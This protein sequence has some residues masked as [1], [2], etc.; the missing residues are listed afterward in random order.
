[1]LATTS[2]RPRSARREYAAIERDVWVETCRTE[3]PV[4]AA[5]ARIA[6]TME[7]SSAWAGTSMKTLRPS[8]AASTASC[9]VGIRSPTPF[10][11]HGSR[12][13]GF[14]AMGSALRSL[15]ASWSPA[16]ARMTSE[17]AR[18]STSAARLAARGPAGWQKRPTTSSSRSSKRLRTEQVWRRALMAWEEEKPWCPLAWARMSRPSTSCPAARRAS[19]SSGARRAPRPRAMRTSSSRRTRRTGRSRAGTVI[20]SAPWRH[21]AVPMPRWM[22]P[23]PWVAARCSERAMIAR[24]RSRARPRAMGSRMSRLRRTG[25][26]V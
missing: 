20:A 18:A 19:E 9:W 2:A 4:A 15:P 25:C 10:S 16:S 21:V 6:A 23:V 13:P 5:S 14:V 17:S 12:S 3:R 26:S 7:A 22:G 24:A 8:E 1:M 11:A